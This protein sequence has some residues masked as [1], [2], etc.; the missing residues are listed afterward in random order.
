MVFRQKRVWASIGARNK[1]PPKGCMIKYM[2]DIYPTTYGKTHLSNQNIG[3]LRLMSEKTLPKRDFPLIPLVKNRVFVAFWR[4][5]QIT[6]Q[7]V[8]VEYIVDM[9]SPT[10]RQLNLSNHNI[11]G[12]QTRY[13]ET[14]PERD[15][16]LVSVKKRVWASLGDPSKSP[17]K[18][19]MPNI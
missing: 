16:P 8:Y 4:R 9:C 19:H 13:G 3:G 7:C 10:R 11:G 15:S 2:V 12:P 6:A 1:S 17:P 14:L 5:V 18:G